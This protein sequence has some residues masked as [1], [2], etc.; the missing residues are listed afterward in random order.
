MIRLRPI[1]RL[2]LAL[3]FVF[4]MLIALAAGGIWLALH[5]SLPRYDGTLQAPGLTAPV[6]IERDDLG[7]VTIRAQDRHDVAW[8]LGYAHAQERFF[9]MDLMRR[10]AAG[11]LAEL[12]GAA[13]LPADR[14][15]RVHRMRARATATFA[16]LPVSQRQLLD[17][18]RDGVNEGLEGLSV[19]QFPYLLTRTHP[20]PWRSE[21]SMLVVKAMYF[22]LNDGS[23][24]RELALSRMRAALPEPVYRF[25]T[26]SGGD[27]DAPLVGPAFRWPDP[28]SAAELNLRN[29][30]PSL[31]R[32]NNAEYGDTVPG[33]NSF[34]VGGQL[35]GGAALV[36]NDT[37]LELRVPNIWFRTR[38]IY[39]SSRRQ[40]ILNDHIGVSLPGTPAIAI[41][42]N[43][44][45]AWGFTNS[46]GDFTDWVRVRLDSA[47][48]MRYRS[49]EGWK[50]LV[51]HR[52]I[53][54][55]R[56]GGDE[57]LD[58]YETEWGP[59][60]AADHDGAP[61][62]LAWTAHRPGVAN[63]ELAQLEDAETVEEALTIAQNSG[64]P[65][66]N[67]IVADRTGRIAWTIAGRI[68]LRI[69]SYDALLPADWSVPETGWKGWLPP[70]QYP[71]IV[72][73]PS[74]RLWTANARAV[75]G[76][77]LERLGNGG[78]DLGARAKQIRDG[79]EQREYFSP[80][81][82][83]AIQLDDRALFLSHWQRLL[84]QTLGEAES[85]G[86]RTEM[87]SALKDWDGHAST[88]SVAYRLVRAFRYEVMH[89]VLDGFAA[90]VRRTDPE[91]AMPRLSQAEHAVWKLIEKR[92]PHLLP[93]V[94]DKWEN[95][96][97][98]CA[99]RVAERMQVEPGGIP[100][101]TWGER[102]TARIRHPLSPSLP[103]FAAG[104]L[105]M[106]RDELPGDTHM[107][108][109]QAPSFGAA[110]RFAV[111]PGKEDKGYLETPGG[112]SGHPLS[113]YYG[114]G[115]ADWVVGRP[116]PF[117]PGQPKQILNLRP[118]VKKQ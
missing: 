75:D 67:F 106:P 45:I 46:Y 85:S 41:G 63:M 74:Q 3:P 54:H 105:D 116:T 117:L 52:E 12:F 26:A 108:R 60:L 7:S 104:W 48:S 93:P 8:A 94:Y 77:M 53:L 10:Q 76:P 111:A 1:Y 73:P 50:S 28:P 118:D 25:L 79:L 66:Q 40:E 51:V 21:D 65:A 43:R 86:W 95:L 78:Y 103:A 5:G 32:Q 107:P 71:L 102:N 19:R 18:Y 36:A 98:A 33:S 29:L 115:H 80:E 72:D 22:T 84:A 30:D 109:V 100:A 62:A 6:S 112:Q 37:H 44:R 42:S 96:L 27:W 47:D 4:L 87:Q 11:E 82:M 39:P 14:K 92:P 59:I 34:A 57:I 24:H 97:T 38:L 91:F 90:A 2:L 99:R 81:D 64:I 89:S 9:E 69:G 101:R 113:P 31:L 83:L 49:A 55:V 114:S 17:A 61:L 70:D 88:N 16:A 23:N 20:A 13:A 58:V 110:N 15:T 35:T 68:P 56:G